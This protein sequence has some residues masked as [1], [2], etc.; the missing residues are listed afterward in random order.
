MVMAIGLVILFAA[1]ALISYRIASGMTSPLEKITRVARRISQ[2]DY[3][4]R[5]DL[6]RK[7][8]IGLLGNAI[9]GMAD[10]L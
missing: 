2:Q 3:D 9:N 5:V 7:D 1:A 8:E 10:S 6:R 4:A